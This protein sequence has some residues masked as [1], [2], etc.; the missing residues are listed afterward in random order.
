[1]IDRALKFYEL[2]HKEVAF[3]LKNNSGKNIFIN[4]DNEQLY[5]VFVNLIKNSIEAIE[6]MKQKDHNLQGKITVEIDKN[7]EYIV[8]RIFDNG[9]GFNETKNITKPYYTTKKNGTGLGLPI[10]SKIINE[11]GGELNFVKNQLGAQID[12]LLPIYK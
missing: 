4:G 9:I 2:S 6:E 3:N 1:M 7:N 12:I 8:I 11:H 5:R 10:V